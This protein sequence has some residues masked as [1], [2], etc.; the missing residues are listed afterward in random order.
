MSLSFQVQQDYGVAA[1]AVLNCDL[2]RYLAVLLRVA[3]IH[4]VSV[5]ERNAAAATAYALAEEAV[6]QQAFAHCDAE[7][8]DWPGLL[9]PLRAPQVAACLFR[10]AC[11]VSWA[12]GEIDPIELEVLMQIA[13]E[14]QLP[15]WQ[16]DRLLEGV[17]EQE[18]A[19]LRILSLFS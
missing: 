15:D 7:A 11:K 3:G 9:V 12:D 17:A 8:P 19:R 2:P 10:D 18:R 16:R 4:E 1:E 5:S 14:L 6:R 13:A